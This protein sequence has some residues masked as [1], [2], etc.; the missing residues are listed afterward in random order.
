MMI[1]NYLQ[2]KY[3]VNLQV[4]VDSLAIDLVVGAFDILSAAFTKKEPEPVIFSLRSFLINRIPV[5]LSGVATAML[6]GDRSEYCIG[7]ALARVDPVMFP[8]PSHGLISENALQDVRQD[9]LFSC[10]LHGLI[11][12]S[13]IESLLGEAPT[14]SQP[15]EPSARY[16][17]ETLVDQCVSDPERIFQLVD[18]LDKMNGNAG[19]I[20]LATVEVK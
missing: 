20:S 19:A 10:T 4:D 7:Q 14:F 2:M 3:K 16:M 18:E 8:P 9:F 1:V 5:L 15:P 12:A 11:R 6:A 13:S 17:K